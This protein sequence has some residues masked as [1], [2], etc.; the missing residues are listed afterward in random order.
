M[1]FRRAA[2]LAIGGFPERLGRMGQTLLSNEET[3]AFLGVERAGGLIRYA[4]AARVH[5]QIAPDRLTRLFFYRRLYWQG[6]SDA[7]LTGVG[8]RRRLRTLLN[9]IFKPLLALAALVVH[10]S[11]SR[12]VY[13]RASLYGMLGCVLALLRLPPWRAPRARMSP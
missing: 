2:L 12:A 7:R 13:L 1:A 3:S 11:R 10:P 6:V 5:H 9:R 8:V 4:P